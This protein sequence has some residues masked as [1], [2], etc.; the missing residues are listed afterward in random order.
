M[1]LDARAMDA[2]AFT[3]AALDESEPRYADA[4]V[5]SARLNRNGY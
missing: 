1:C 4:I 2:M 5:H 3:D